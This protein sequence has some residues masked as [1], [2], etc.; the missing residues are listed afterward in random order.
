MRWVVSKKQWRFYHQEKL[1]SKE[2]SKLRRREKT[3]S[4]KQQTNQRSP[5]LL[6]SSSHKSMFT[7]EAI[8]RRKLRESRKI[9][10]RQTFLMS[11]LTRI[12]V[13]IQIKW[14][15]RISSRLKVKTKEKSNKTPMN[16]VMTVCSLSWIKRSVT[17]VNSPVKS[18]NIWTRISLIGVE[19]LSIPMTRIIT[20]R[21]V[22]VYRIVKVLSEVA[23]EKQTKLI[24]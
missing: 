8:N 3:L 15:T 16:S 4:L 18:F 21:H 1:K 19:P 20:R 2:T 23:R 17:S 12:M 13:M 7:I 9:S 22:N 10:I 11:S 5:E 24:I 6:A 14:M